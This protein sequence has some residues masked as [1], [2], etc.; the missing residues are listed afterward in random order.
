[1]RTSSAP[2]GRPTSSPQ[3]PAPPREARRPPAAATPPVLTCDQQHQR[4][5]PLRCSRARHGACGADRKRGRRSLARHF[6]CSSLARTAPLRVVC[7]LLPE[8]W[9]CVRRSNW[10]RG[11][12]ERGASSQ[13]ARSPAERGFQGCPR[14]R[15]SLPKSPTP[16]LATPNRRTDPSNPPNRSRHRSRRSSV[17]RSKVHHCAR[18]PRARPGESAFGRVL[19]LRSLSNGVHARGRASQAPEQQ[20]L[21]TLEG[22]EAGGGGHGASTCPAHLLPNAAWR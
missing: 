3:L 15:R 22:A 16:P 11:R 17:W 12:F 10:R 19:V 18:I 21:G 2:R 13:C 9:P 5:E 20:P 4:Q 1:M 6:L 7:A 8:K 14:P